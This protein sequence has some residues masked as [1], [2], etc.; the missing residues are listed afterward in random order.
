MI[1]HIVL[2]FLFWLAIALGDAL[3]RALGRRPPARDSYRQ[4]L[5]RAR[6]RRRNRAIRR[7]VRKRSSRGIPNVGLK[8]SHCDYP[9]TGLRSTTC[10]ECGETF[11]LEAMIDPSV[12][13]SRR[14]CGHAHNPEHP[15][16]CQ[17]CGSTTSRTCKKCGYAI[18]GMS[19]FQPCPRCGVKPV[20][21][22]QCCYDVTRNV[23]G[24]CPEWGIVLD[25]LT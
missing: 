22:R 5:E 7:W 18:K 21:C 6:I 10:P 3:L 17:V 25:A 23:T 9:L 1:A 4:R 14:K 15:H 24:Q 13:G 20:Y 2:E 16:W 11:D 19:S 12:E 8:C